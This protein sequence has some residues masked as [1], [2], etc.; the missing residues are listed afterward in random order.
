MEKYSDAL[1]DFKKALEINPKALFV[2]YN[3]GILNYRMKKYEKALDIFKN[4]L[5]IEPD[6]GAY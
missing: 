5:E 1:N 3:I 2:K 4:L 6:E